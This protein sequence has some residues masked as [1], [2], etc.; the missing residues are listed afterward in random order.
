MSPRII[1]SQSLQLFFSIVYV[2]IACGPFAFQRLLSI[3]VVFVNLRQCITS[4]ILT[5]VMLLLD[6]SSICVYLNFLIP[7]IYKLLKLGEIGDPCLIDQ[8][9]QS[10][11][12]S[13]F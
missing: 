12:F 2:V 1:V 13:S 7:Q 5:S 8:A 10:L 11:A 4:M 3:H 9:I 6:L